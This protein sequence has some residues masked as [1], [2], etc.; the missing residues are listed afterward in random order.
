M[1]LAHI[2]ILCS[3]PMSLAAIQIYYY[4]FL[5]GFKPQPSLSLFWQFFYRGLFKVLQMSSTPTRYSNGPLTHALGPCPC[6][7]PL[8]HTRVPCPCPMPLSHSLFHALVPFPF[9]CHC[10]ILLS[11]I[12]VTCPCPMPRCPWPMPCPLSLP[13]SPLTQA[14]YHAFAP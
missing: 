11:H 5:G 9:P 1:A 8:Q 4:T 3:F 12:L 13:R 10:P 14:F 6:I 7:M 2:V